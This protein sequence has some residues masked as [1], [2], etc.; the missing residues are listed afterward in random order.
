MSF[1][2][3][4]STRVSLKQTSPCQ[5]HDRHEILSPTL[6]KGGQIHYNGLQITEDSGTLI[7][8]KQS[9]RWCLRSLIPPQRLSPRDGRGRRHLLPALLRVWSKIGRLSRKTRTARNGNIYLKRRT[10]YLIRQIGKHYL[11]GKHVFV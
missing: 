1:T 9:A 8:P 2:V 11:C 5:E 10:H 6:E 4:P 3:M 7:L